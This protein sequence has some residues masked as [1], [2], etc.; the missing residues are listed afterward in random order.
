MEGITRFRGIFSDAEL[1]VYSFKISSANPL[2]FSFIWMELWFRSELGIFPINDPEKRVEWSIEAN[3]S[4]VSLSYYGFPV[5]SNCTSNSYKLES[6]VKFLM[7][8]SLS[9]LKFIESKR[10]D[11]LVFDVRCDFDYYLLKQRNL[12]DRVG[13]FKGSLSFFIKLTESEWLKI[14]KE[15]KYSDRMLIELDA[16]NL[17]LPGMKGFDEVLKKIDQANTKLSE[18]AN[19]EDILSDLRSAWDLVDKYINDY[20]KEI[21][22]LIKDKS[23]EEKTQPP[24]EERIEKIHKAMLSYLGSINDLKES[25]DKFTQIGPHREIYHSTMEDAEL[26]FRLTT[27]LIAYYSKLLSKISTDSE[28]NE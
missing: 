2:P 18:R 14:L 26:A 27:S 22:K 6:N 3:P 19:P 16:P 1:E 12:L 17:N 7:P 9:A 25:I 10:K 23:K 24:K 13:P 15:L 5:S 11:D 21:N 28:V 8:I 4:S 20:N